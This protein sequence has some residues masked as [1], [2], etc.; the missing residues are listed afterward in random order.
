MRYSLTALLLLMLSLPTTGQDHMLSKAPLRQNPYIQLPLG[1]IQPQGWL[2]EMLIRQKNGATGKL[3][4]LYPI[5]MNQRNGWLG[6]DGDQ[7]ERGPY[8]ID[9][10]LPLA[11]LL[12][13]KELI[14]KTKPW[15]EWAIKSQQ[16]D[17]YFGPSQD[18]G[19]EPGIQRDNSRDWWPKM[20]MLKVLQQYYSATGDKRVIHLMTSYFKYQL[21]ELP[22]KPLDHWTFWA[23]Y[24][25]GD[26]LMVVYWLYNITG[27]KFLLDLG[28][29]I[30]KQTFN[31]T[32][33]FLNTN[34]LSTPGSIHCVNLAQGMKAPLI[35]YQHHPEEEYLQATKKGFADLRKY[36]GMAH[37]L[38]G[39][40][41][42]LHGNNP[43]QGSELC[44]AVEMMFSLENAIE[45]TGDVSYADH[46]EKIAFNA[47]PSQT[48]EDYMARQYFQQANQ[49]M[50]SR[51]IRNFDQNHTETDV[52]YGLL[53]GYPCCTSNMHQGWPKF[54]QNLWYATP[55]NGLAALVYSPCEVK[56][57]TGSFKE[58][59]N[60]PFEETV[61]FTY[62]T[63]GTSVSFPLH[64]RIPA[65]CK[66]AIIKING[67]TTQEPTGNQIVKISREWRSG[68]I[69]ELTLPMHIFSNSWYESSIS[70]ERGP[71]TY[72]LKIGEDVRKITNEK[73]PR[74]YGDHYYEVHPTTP[75]NYG[76]F[77]M[78]NDKMQERYTV[79]T[80][81][82]KADYPWTQA[83][84]P[85][86]IKTKAK[87]VPSWQLYNEMTGPM[88]YAFMNNLAPGK[89]EEEITLIPYGCTK[90]HISQFPVVGRK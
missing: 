70:V 3:D 88:P 27:D 80:T 47:L 74:T 18:Y 82:K 50:I 42:A 81:G 83:N 64:L 31:Y 40:D 58:E 46:L 44:S 43:T 85:I 67:K 73:D 9:G 29:L 89:E 61:K 54:A 19:H 1:A 33:A 41:E 20:V 86:L 76:L 62:T 13:D 60:Y 10:L 57:Q 23:K 49:V 11:Y 14:A 68:D 30:H 45:I 65:W 52:C 36:N 4:E 59:T 71:I 63:K 53:T 34:L 35:Y 22:Q 77:D 7:W 12:H 26:N 5:V 21:K 16:P 72:A 69:V 38:F 84:V 6:G 39:G 55:D 56:T 78:K 37:G 79:E 75:W 90:L 28:D 24:R 15:V 87:R 17:G 25:G 32:N 48:T 51:Y 8:W 66:K 2:K